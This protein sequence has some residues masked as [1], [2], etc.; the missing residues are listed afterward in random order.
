MPQASRVGLVEQARAAAERRDWPQAYAL[1]VAAD[2]SA[3]LAQPELGLLAQ[4]AYAAGHVDVTIETWERAHA[5]SL[6]AGDALAAAGASVR[7]AMH[8]MMDTALIAP[9]RGWLTRAE[10]LL[11]GFGDTPVHAWLAVVRNYERLLSGDFESARHWAQRAI[12]VG[13]IHELAAAALGRVALARSMILRG[14]VQRGLALLD[15]AAVATLTGELDPLTTGMVYCEVVCALQGV[16]QYARAEEWTQAMER[17]RHAHAIGSIHGRCRVHRAEILRM[18][19]SCLE[20]EAEALQACEELRPYLRRELG[21]PLSEL[22]RIRFRRGD[23]QGAEAAFLEAHEVGWDPQPGLALVHLARGDTALAAASIREALEHPSPVPSKELPPNTELRRVPLLE[24]QVEIEV[25]AGD[26]DRA[27]SAADELARVATAFQSNALAASAALAEGRVCLAQRDGAGA[28]RA[29]AAAVRQWSDIG[30]PYETALARRGLA[31]ALRA[32]GQDE[33]ALLELR[34]ARATFERIGAARAA[35]ACG[36]QGQP[37]TT[38]TITRPVTPAARDV[39]P[40]DASVFC[41]EGDYWLVVFAGQTVRLRDAKGL[42][43][44]ARLIAEPGREL[45]ALELVA[46]EAGA[47]DNPN[48]GIEG[49]HAEGDAGPLLDVHA[50]EAYRRRLAEIDEDIAEAR[51]AGD[52]G[53]AAQAESE[54]EFLVRELARAVGLGGR[55]RRAGSASERA[56]SAVTRAVRQALGRIRE[57]HTP[58]ADHFD[59]TIRTGSQCVYLPDPR[60]P[61]AWKT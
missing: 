23:L 17:W 58:L 30:A 26:L 1:L 36:E 43:Y 59:R 12:D 20:A 2:A 3:P 19:G 31:D 38:H 14:D 45:T 53:R 13:A 22:G 42:R 18:R 40:S 11:E 39:P 56:R 6:R 48:D 34:A 35:Q 4:A 15:E 57:H 28:C 24:A 8:L 9:V 46:L 29:F 25:S 52:S 5:D 16:A 41:C 55:E 21:W 10:R 50:K 47:P 54:R 60:M 33:R 7:V 51:S 49:L 61:L 27:R 44:L 37:G 32:E